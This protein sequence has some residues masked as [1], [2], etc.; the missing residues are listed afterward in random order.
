V[1]YHYNTITYL[2]SYIPFCDCPHVESHCWYHV[3]IELAR[4]IQSTVARHLALKNYVT[5]ITHS[6]HCHSLISLSYVGHTRSWIKIYQN[7]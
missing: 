3:F 5:A 6:Y 2:N 4:L 7:E 1:K